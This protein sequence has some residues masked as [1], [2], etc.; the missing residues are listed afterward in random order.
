M[1]DSDTTELTETERTFALAEAR[2]TA[3]IEILEGGTTPRE[4]AER[5][6]VPYTYVLR[7]MGRTDVRKAADRG[8]RIRIAALKAQAVEIGEAAIQV[9]DEV[10]KDPTVEAHVRVEAA[11]AGLLWSLGRPGSASPEHHEASRSPPLAVQVNV[12]TT[13]RKTEG[14]TTFQERLEEVLREPENP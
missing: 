7:V 2:R 12:G 6:G 1:A 14:A 13:D 8:R 10:M 5:L 9:L 11:K 4:A 3:L